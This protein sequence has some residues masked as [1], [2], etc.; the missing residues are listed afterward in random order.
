VNNLIQ[1]EKLKI[2]YRTLH[3]DAKALDDVS[4]TINDKE[5]VGIAGESGCGR[6]EAKGGFGNIYLAK[7]RPFDSG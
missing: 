5:I 7:S 1:I 6:D 4:F 3:G 2:Y